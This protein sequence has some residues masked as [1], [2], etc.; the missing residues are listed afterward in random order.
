MT[1]KDFEFIA[2][3][4]NEMGNVSPAQKQMLAEWFARHLR[5]TNPRFKESMFIEACTK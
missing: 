1:R 3:V 4:I 5:Q 2:N